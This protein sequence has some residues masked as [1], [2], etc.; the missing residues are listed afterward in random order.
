MDDLV[1]NPRETNRFSGYSG[2]L[3]TRSRGGPMPTSMATKT[4]EDLSEAPQPSC[5]TC[6]YFCPRGGPN[7][8]GQC[9]RRSPSVKGFPAAKPTNWCGEHPSIKAWWADRELDPEAN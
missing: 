8:S 4:A 6:I 1:P 9:R 3:G 5:S 2:Y 7:G